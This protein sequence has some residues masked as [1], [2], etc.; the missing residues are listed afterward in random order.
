VVADLLWKRV[1]MSS[2]FIVFRSITRFHSFLPESKKYCAHFI[3]P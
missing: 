3:V 2:P 1:L